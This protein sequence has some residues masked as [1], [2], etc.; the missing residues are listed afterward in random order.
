[1]TVDEVEQAAAA[2]LFVGGLS[3]WK[4][5]VFVERASVTLLWV[6]IWIPDSEDL[7]CRRMQELGSSQGLDP[8]ELEKDE[9]PPEQYVVDFLQ[10]FFL[11]EFFESILFRGNRVFD[12]HVA[13]A[14]HP[15]AL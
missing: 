4:P 7:F 1:M 6:K 15:G 13:G 2:F 11:H 9:R 14:Y 8:A 12:P 3:M 5:R 10:R